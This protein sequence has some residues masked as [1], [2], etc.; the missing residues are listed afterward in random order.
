MIKSLIMSIL[1]HTI[2]QKVDEQVKNKFKI[3]LIPLD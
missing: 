1:H 2:K 3:S